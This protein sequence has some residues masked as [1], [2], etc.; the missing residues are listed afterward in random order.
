MDG[1]SPE[2]NTG[3]N[4]QVA[5]QAETPIVATTPTPTEIPTSGLRGKLLSMLGL[6]KKEPKPFIEEKPP[7][8][9][10]SEGRARIDRDQLRQ[11]L[12]EPS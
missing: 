7:V 12:E 1:K 3:S 9:A 4:D 6:G 10:D 2:V 8:A 5:A 11:K